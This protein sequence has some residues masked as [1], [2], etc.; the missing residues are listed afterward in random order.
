MVKF[1]KQ[2]LSTLLNKCR[3]MLP[4]IP[5]LQSKCPSLNS[6]DFDFFWSSL[7]S[8]IEFSKSPYVPFNFILKEESAEQFFFKSVTA[9]NKIKS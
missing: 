1:A 9:K 3:G 8:V 4:P 2:L 5:S 6:S 7:L